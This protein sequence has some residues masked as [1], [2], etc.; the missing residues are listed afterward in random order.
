MWFSLYEV[1][2]SSNLINDDRSHNS[3]YLWGGSSRDW[4]G[5]FWNLRGADNFLYPD[6]GGGK[7]GCNIPQAENVGILC[8]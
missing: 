5:V 1:Q 2:E 4:E 8:F 7:Y 6:L 3:G